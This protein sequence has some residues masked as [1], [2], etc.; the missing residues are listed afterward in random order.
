[1]KLKTLKKNHSQGVQIYEYNGRQKLLETIQDMGR[2]RN[3]VGIMTYHKTTG[4]IYCFKEIG[5][6]IYTMLTGRLHI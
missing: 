3:I 5:E 4:M 2:S 1:M 6:I